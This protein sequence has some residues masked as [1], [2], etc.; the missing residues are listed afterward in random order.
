MKPKMP[1]A[2]RVGGNRGGWARQRGQAAQSIR[3]PDIASS[4]L[5]TSETV[6][7]VI[8]IRS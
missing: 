7:I 4:A 8:L 1:G 5:W 6:K 2:E 3:P